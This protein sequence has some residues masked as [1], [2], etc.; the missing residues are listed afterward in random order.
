[1]RVPLHSHSHCPTGL[2]QQLLA[3]PVCSVS[4]FQNNLPKIYIRLVTYFETLHCLPM[5][6]KINSKQ[7]LFM[8]WT[9]NSFLS[10]VGAYSPFWGSSHCLSKHWI[11]LE[12]DPETAWSAGVWCG[13]GLGITKS[14]REKS[15]KGLREKSGCDKS[16]LAWKLPDNCKSGLSLMPWRACLS[17]HPWLQRSQTRPLRDPQVSESW[18]GLSGLS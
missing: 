2:L 15:R 12:A 4:C 18:Y 1:M 16:Q 6:H 3:S 11:P 10:I 5:P 17:A 7:G 9:V 8:I 13:Q 14:R